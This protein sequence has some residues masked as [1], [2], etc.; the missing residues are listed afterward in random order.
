MR[1]RATCNAC[2]RDFL[3]FEL[4]HGDPGTTDRCP[5]CRQPLGVRGILAVRAEQALAI[6]AHS[7]EELARHEPNFTIREKSVLTPIEE[8][9]APLATPP[10]TQPMERPRAA[11]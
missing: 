2:H 11:A 10:A 5:N 3:F 1:I 9:L 6:L 7:L 4:R 8:A